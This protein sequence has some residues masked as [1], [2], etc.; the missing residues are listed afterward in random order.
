MWQPDKEFKTPALNGFKGDAPTFGWAL[1]S[2]FRVIKII[3]KSTHVPL[4]DEGGLCGQKEPTQG[5]AVM[6]PTSNAR[7]FVSIYTCSID[8]RHYFVISPKSLQWCALHPVVFTP[9]QFVGAISYSYL[10][11]KFVQFW[12]MNYWGLCWEI[13]DG[14][15]L[16]TLLQLETLTDGVRSGWCDKPLNL[17]ST[18]CVCR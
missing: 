15:S 4:F 18:L 9:T 17:I 6:G 14:P 2:I 5:R 3:R 10:T 12:A 1:K 16:Y 11:K 13:D 7:G 8:S